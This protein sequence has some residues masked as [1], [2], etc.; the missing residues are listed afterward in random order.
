MSHAY[1]PIG[2][3]PTPELLFVGS[4]LFADT[5]HV[6]PVLELV[7]DDDLDQVYLRPV[8]AVI[9]DLVAADRLHDGAVVGGELQRRGALAGESGRLTLRA[10][11]D[12]S[13]SGAV[14]NHSAPPC[15]AAA[16]V[17]D[18]YRRRFETAGHALAEA[19]MDFAE[20][21][22]LPLLRSVGTEAV[23]HAE[24]LAK[25]RGVA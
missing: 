12:A 21:D 1:P 13:T 6:K 25:L 3:D 10:L 5:E 9:R 8:L 11:A 19:A 16:V 18:A 14:A 2:P 4:L 22:L 23:R 17:A 15:Y 20:D 24:R 7:A